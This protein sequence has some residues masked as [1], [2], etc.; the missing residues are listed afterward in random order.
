M[1]RIIN[2]TLIMEEKKFPWLLRLLSTNAICVELLET[3]ALHKEKI[4]SS[5]V[6]TSK[7]ELI[8]KPTKSLP[9]TTLNALTE[10]IYLQTQGSATSTIKHVYF[11]YKSK[12]TEVF[13]GLLKSF[14]MKKKSIPPVSYIQICRFPLKSVVKWEVEYTKTGF[15]SVITPESTSLGVLE[16]A[17]EVS[18][19]LISLIE[20]HENKKVLKISLEFVID[21]SC[22]AILSYM[23]CCVLAPKQQIQVMTQKFKQ[24][25]YSKSNELNDIVNEL[26]SPSKILK[27]QPSIIKIIDRKNSFIDKIE[28]DSP[29]LK[30]VNNSIESDTSSQESEPEISDLV[31][32]KK[33]KYEKNFLEILCKT[34]IAQKSGLKKYF[35]SENELKDEKD[36]IVSIIEETNKKAKENLKK[37]KISVDFKVLDRK[38]SANFSNLRSLNIVKG[39]SKRSGSLEDIV[40]PVLSAKT[41]RT[42]V[43]SKNMWFN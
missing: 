41:H 35:Y 28:I 16:Q 4:I 32:Q 34:R 36:K 21:L 40:L 2:P 19:E 27:R 24:S 39:I 26:S 6:N 18:K 20:L 12:R 43:P 42:Q 25:P 5:F 14:S 23:P 38:K 13:Q 37:S 3:F 31:G 11:I 10:N 8:Q 17:K 29:V 30:N 7:Y 33:K 22:K 9:Y 15:K 1:K